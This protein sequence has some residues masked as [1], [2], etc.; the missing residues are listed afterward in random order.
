MPRTNDVV[1]GFPGYGPGTSRIEAIRGP[2]IESDE[3][4]DDDSPNFGKGI[5]SD[6]DENFQSISDVDREPVNGGKRDSNWRDRREQRTRT[7]VQPH[8]QAHLE[9]GAD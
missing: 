9:D 1:T 5:E 6:F 8:L 2:V 7:D 4:G 3:H